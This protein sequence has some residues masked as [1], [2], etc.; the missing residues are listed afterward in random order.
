MN[1]RRFRVNDNNKIYGRRKK[2]VNIFFLGTVEN[3]WQ[4]EENVDKF[5]LA[6]VY[7]DMYTKFIRL[8]TES[9]RKTFNLDAA[10]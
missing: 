5:T 8:F 7:N 4:G 9:I 10:T 3:S 1:C 2:F 6:T